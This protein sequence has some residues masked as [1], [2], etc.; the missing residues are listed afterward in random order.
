MAFFHG[1]RV[2]I[3]PGSEPR[4]VEVTSGIAFVVGTAPVHTVNGAVNEVL[5]FSAFPEARSALGY[6]DDWEKYTL[7]EV[8]ECHFREFLVGPVFFVNVLDIARHRRAVQAA[9]YPV[10]DR[11]V[12]LPFEAIADTVKVDGG[13]RGADFAVFYTGGACVLEIVPGGALAGKSTV[14]V[15]YEAVDPGLV[16]ALDIIGGQDVVTGARSGFE[17]ISVCI[18]KYQV[19]PDLIICPKW[20]KGPAVAAVMDAKTFISSVLYASALVDLPAPGGTKYAEV[21]ELKKK[22]GNFTSGDT[23]LCWPKVRRAGKVYHLSTRMA[24]VISRTDAANDGFPSDSPS[25]RPLLADSAV[26]D[27]GTEVLLDLPEA[28]Y[29]NANGI[30]TALNFANGWTLWGNYTGAF[31]ERTHPQYAF[32][33]VN[34][35]MKRLA[36]STVLEFWRRTDGRMTRRFVGALVDEANISMNGLVSN[37]HLLGGRVEVFP[38][39]N[40][41]EDLMAGIIRPHIFATPPSPAQKID[42]SLEY[43]MGYFAA[44]FS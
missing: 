41:V 30:V 2:G 34:R 9:P 7:S 31:P 37:G 14:S 29:L 12:K 21:P 6:S 35:M 43:D 39:A 44:L 4:T 40:P 26:L 5:R 18:P 23:S 10:Q 42:W 11:Q 36:N 33:S 25:N 38:E 27:D 28:N 22:A 19:A 17:L 13:E 15:E 3:V 1:N 32:L 20:S 24:A 8:M 16:T